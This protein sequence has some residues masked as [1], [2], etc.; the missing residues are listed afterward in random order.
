VPS[1]DSRRLM[2]ASSRAAVTLTALVTSS[3]T[4]SSASEANQS[5]PHSHSRFLACNRAHATA[6]GSAPNCRQSCDGH[7]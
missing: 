6:V 3:E 5:T 7:G 4:R 2:A 1:L